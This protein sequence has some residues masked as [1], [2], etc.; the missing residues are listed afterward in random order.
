MLFSMDE[1][2]GIADGYV[3]DWVITD[4]LA[5]F[6]IKAA[7]EKLKNQETPGGDGS[8]AACGDGSSACGGCGGSV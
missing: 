8:G 6:D 4:A 5:K 3:Y 7:S 2:Y 1:E